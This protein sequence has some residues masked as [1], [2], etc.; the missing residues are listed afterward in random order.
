MQK[1]REKTACFAIQTNDSADLIKAA[2]FTEL[3]G[4]DDIYYDTLGMENCFSAF[5]SNIERYDSVLCSNDIMALFLQN[6][7]KNYG[8]ST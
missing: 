4:P 7:C 6:K 1:S 5:L 3:L 8:Y 2:A